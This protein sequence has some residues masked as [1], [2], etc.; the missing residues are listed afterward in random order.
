MELFNYASKPFQL[1]PLSL[2]VSDDVCKAMHRYVDVMLRSEMAKPDYD[3]R[4]HTNQC[5]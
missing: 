5:K 2:S 1:L 3:L 4:V